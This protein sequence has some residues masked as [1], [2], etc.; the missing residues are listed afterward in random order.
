MQG[1]AYFNESAVKQSYVFAIDV[2]ILPDLK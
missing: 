1:I 2:L